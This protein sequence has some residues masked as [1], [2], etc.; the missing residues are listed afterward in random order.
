MFAA[1]AESAGVALQVRAAADLPTVSADA[2]RVL[3]ALSNLVTNALKFTGAGGRVT[4][5]AE[6]DGADVRFAVEDTGTGIS[7]EDL[8]HVFDRF[9]HKRRVAQPGSGLGLPIVRGIV[10]AHGGQVGVESTPGQGSR[11][12]FTV[13][14]AS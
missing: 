13:P 3:Q 14:S 6:P 5:S 4:L 2:G 8:P 10:E 7:A 9:W 1:R 11:F 12:S